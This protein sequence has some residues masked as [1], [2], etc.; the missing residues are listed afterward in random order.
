[1]RVLQLAGALVVLCAVLIAPAFAQPATPAG[2]WHDSFGTSFHISECGDGTALCIV[3]DDIGGDMR[4]PSNLKYVNT[5]V[6]QAAQHAE[7]AWK[8][9]AVFA[10]GAVTATIKL[11]SADE[12]EATGCI[13]ILCSMLPFT[14]Y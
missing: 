13:T 14:R 11:V 6:L 12:I 3:L 7:N 2:K 5:Q 1:M 4:T 10:G 8:G 9:H